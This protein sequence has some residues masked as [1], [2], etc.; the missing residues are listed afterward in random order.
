MALAKRQVAIVSKSI[1]LTFF[2]QSQLLR[3]TA[4]FYKIYWLL[5]IFKSCNIV[6]NIFPMEAF[7]HGLITYIDTKAKCSH[8]KIFPGKGLCGRCLS[9]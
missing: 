7:S 1:F 6:S 8:L 3:K 9:V 2:F 4:Q 5:Q